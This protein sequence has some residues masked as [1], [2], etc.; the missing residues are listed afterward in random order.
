V[1]EEI[2]GSDVMRVTFEA[3]AAE[4]VSLQ[5]AVV[6]R[7]GQQTVVPYA[8]LVYDPAG[9]VWVYTVTEPLTYVR[10]PVE[11]DRIIGDRVWLVS[12]PRPGA[13]VV[14]VGATEVYGAELD[15]AGGH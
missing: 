1:A 2:K 5:T 12:G 4:R 11:V 13:R 14:T 3:D 10:A 7:S 9:K 6:R 8:A 15:I